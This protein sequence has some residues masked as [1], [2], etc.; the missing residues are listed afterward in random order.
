MED[1]GFMLPCP[2]RDMDGFAKRM[3][4]Y[5]IASQCFQAVFA[6]MKVT[7]EEGDVERLMYEPVGTMWTEHSERATIRTWAEAAQIP[8]EDGEVDPVSRASL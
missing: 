2:N 7:M 1:R 5:A 8:E 3:A 6:D 4:S